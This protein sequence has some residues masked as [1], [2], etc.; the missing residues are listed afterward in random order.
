MTLNNVPQSSHNFSLD[1]NPLYGVTSVFYVR[2]Q[3][4]RPPLRRHTGSR[5]AW[6]AEEAG[7]SFLVHVKRKKESL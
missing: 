4:F 5:A 3:I 6:Y 1:L 2:A 7:I